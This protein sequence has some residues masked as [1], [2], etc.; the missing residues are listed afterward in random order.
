MSGWRRLHAAACASAGLLATACASPLPDDP[1][2]QNR[3]P[4]RPAIINPFPRYFDVVPA[5]LALT[6]TPY[7]D[8][9]GDPI[10]GAELELWTLSPAGEL[11]TPV[12]SASFPQMPAA[13]RLVDGQ[14]NFGI[15]DLTAHARYAARVRYRDAV[16]AG[17]GE[18][19][20]DWG[21]W[22]EPRPFGTDDGSAALFDPDR[23]QDVHLE[24]PPES[25]SAMDAQAIPPGC[26]PYERDYQRGAIVIG[27]QRRANVGIKI[28]GGCGSS[29]DLSEKASFKVN[30][31]WDDPA[32]A[33][34]PD[35]AR[36]AGQRTLALDNGVQDP[37]SSNQR[38]GFEFYEAMGVAAPR[39]A[40]ARLY[41]NGAY[42]GVYT[43]V[44]TV[45]RRMLSRWYPSDRG[46]LY[47]G[48]YACDLVTANLPVDGGDSACLTREFRPGP[49]D[50]PRPG[51]DP[52]TYEP[53][54][55]LI[56][57]IDALVPGDYVQPVER[58]LAL[59]EYLSQ[60]AADAVLRNWDSYTFATINNYRVY[61]DP[62]LD[63]WHL[64]QTGIDQIMGIDDRR[65]PP[66][67][68]PLAP[69]G[70]LARKCLQDPACKARFARRLREAAAIFEAMQLHRRASAI[71]TQLR[72][73]LERDPRREFSMNEFDAAF[74]ARQDWIVGR[75]GQIRDLLAASGL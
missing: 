50:D 34:C 42:W 74:A 72:A 73:D 27:D 53:L 39:T 16:D 25:R 55:G 18:T 24:I 33:G 15:G 3:L 59:D 13:V 46:M 75:P 29:R 44:E 14:W 68:D 12:W 11:V 7:Q 5:E 10:G 2:L 22:S 6:A 41:V 31:A 26:V 32:V 70:R 56:A 52:R 61:H 47:E 65:D 19:C 4:L 67:F 9:D 37:T 17:A 45:E 1:C 28:K 43:L 20:G 48:S 57:D 49:C 30:L 54:R 58:F 62:A 71:Q 66:R 51:D 38:L 69:S 60:W 40:S 63:R 8:P 23:V 64:V 35:G 21:P 36:I